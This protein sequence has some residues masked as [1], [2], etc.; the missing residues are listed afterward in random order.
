MKRTLIARFLQRSDQ[1]EGTAEI[2]A[3]SGVVVVLDRNGELIVHRG[4]VL[5]EDRKQAAK[6]AAAA[7]GAPPRTG[8]RAT[9]Q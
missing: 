8:R 3:F 7:A 5:P 1:S 6:A 9:R 2:L 4:I